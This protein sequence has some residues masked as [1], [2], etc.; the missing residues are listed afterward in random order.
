LKK[1]KIVF[2]S[3]LCLFIFGCI[4]YDETVELNKDGSGKITMHYSIPQQLFAMMQMGQDS[5][6]KK[7]EMPFKFK[8]SE[9]RSDLTAPGVTVDKVEEKTEGDQHH[10]YVTLS[11]KKITDLNQTKSFTKMPFT[12][13]EEGKNILFQQV[14]IGEKKQDE[15]NPMGDQM[16]SAMM[17]NA[18]FT[19]KVTLPAKPLPAPDTNGTVQADGKTV[20]WEYPILEASKGQTMTARFPAGGF[21]LPISPLMLG[22][23]GGGLLISLIALVVIIKLAKKM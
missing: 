2:V 5:G 4:N 13:K 12:W 14:L 22:A 6:E 11:F 1:Y 20:V 16:A 17:G 10:F 23:I 21:S 18:K 3:I 9:I 7:E 15:S 8:E 19:F